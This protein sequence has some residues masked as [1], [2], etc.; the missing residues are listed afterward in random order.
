[1]YVHQPGQYGLAFQVDDN[2]RIGNS[3]AE[4]DIDDLALPY[5]NGWV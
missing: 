2:G 3:P 4:I 1:M 5:D